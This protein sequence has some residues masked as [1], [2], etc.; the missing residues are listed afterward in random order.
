[1]RLVFSENMHLLRILSAAV[2][3]AACSIS[4]QMSPEAIAQQPGFVRAE[5]IAQ[6]PPTPSSHA[7]TIVES[8]GDLLCAWFGGTKERALDVSIWLSRNAGAGWSEPAEVANGVH[9]EERVRYPC[10]NPVLFRPKDGPLVLFYKEG[11][12]PESWWGMMKTSEDNGQ[13][14]SRPKRLF[15]GFY[16][17][18]RNKPIQLEDGTILA[19]SS[20]EHTGWL[21]HIERTKNIMREWTKSDPLNSSMEWGAIQPTLLAWPDGTIQMLCRTKQRKITQAY[22]YDKGYKWTR[23][24][25]T[26]LPNPNSAIDAV[27]LRDGHAA[28]AYNHSEDDRGTLNLAISH[29]GRRWQAAMVLENEPGAEFS[30]PAIIQTADK[31]IHVTYT[32]KRQGIRHVTVDPSLLRLQPIVSGVWP[33]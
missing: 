4:A 6:Q 11:P 20:V 26:E 3:L 9:D 32:W 5:F 23:M 7:S 2:S 27:M 28:L 19:G 10:W 13:T 16:G 8:K 1:M 17:P 21:T 14:W 25:A 15:S 33:R 24:R 18:I 12:S 29:D 30:Y 22:S 31:M